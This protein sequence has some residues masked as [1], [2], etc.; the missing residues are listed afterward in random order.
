MWGEAVAACGRE[1]GIDPATAVRKIGVSVV[2]VRTAV[3]EAA[4]V[5]AP[6]HPDSLVRRS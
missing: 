5:V 2:A 6:E 1:E 4:A 3:A